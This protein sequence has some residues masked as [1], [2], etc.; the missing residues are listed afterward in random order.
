MKALQLARLTG[1]MGR[2][3]GLREIRVAMIDGPVERDHPGFRSSDFRE[4]PPGKQVT[5]SASDS[6]ACLHGTFIAG[7]LFA[8]R[9]SG[10][11][12][13]CPGCT[14]LLRPIFT[15]PGAGA[16]ALPVA[17][18]DEL[19]EAIV[20][21]VNA[22]AHILNLSLAVIWPSAKGERALTAAL[23]WAVRKQMI[24]V[25]AAGNQAT[26]GGS[27]ITRHPGVIP[28]VACDDAGRPLGDATLAG[29]IGRRGLCAP[30]DRVTSLAPNGAT[31]TLSGTSVAAP[32]VTG[33]A[34]LLWSSFRSATAA[35]VRIALA[36]PG[37][38]KRGSI[39]PPVLNASE[40]LGALLPLQ[41]R[42]AE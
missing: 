36:G 35:Q 7:I 8:D 4:I 27:V 31:K 12:G 39:V 33:A 41:A 40:A 17:T 34:A 11:P 32:F 14:A 42:P 10:A 21:C 18:P 2:S 24:V 30:G 28:V 23:D 3:I 37:S 19:A 13:L 6:S 20:E 25:A 5:C 26:V 15:E 29:S 9:R 22:G 1:M 16:D 38:R